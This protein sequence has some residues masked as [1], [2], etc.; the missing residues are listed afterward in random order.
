M[1][2][3]LL[4]A[5]KVHEKLADAPK[6]HAGP[7]PDQLSGLLVGFADKP[8]AEALGTLLY[9]IVGL[10]AASGVDAE[11]ALFRATETAISAAE[12]PEN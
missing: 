5:Q 7:T 4:R 1:L 3:A 6:K 2:P 8:D 12:S 9:G 10:A 11:E